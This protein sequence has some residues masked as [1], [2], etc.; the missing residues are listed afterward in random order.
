MW[1]EMRKVDLGFLDCVAKT[2]VVSC[3]LGAA[4]HDLMQTLFQRAM[5][6]LDAYLAA[7][8]AMPSHCGARE[9]HAT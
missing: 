2:S 6:N 4:R 8:R 9:G 1:F 3:T 7:Q 5:A